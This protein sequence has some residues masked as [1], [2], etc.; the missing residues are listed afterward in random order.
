MVRRNWA[1][2]AQLADPNR[3][4]DASVWTA[5]AIDRLGQIAARMA[6][7]DRGD[8]LHAA[9]GL[10]DLRIGRNIIQVRLGLEDAE[11]YT[12][13]SIHSALSEVSALYL[14]RLRKGEALI[15][16]SSLLS[17]L[18]QAINVSLDKTSGLGDRALLALVGMRCNFIPNAKPFEVTPR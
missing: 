5:H 17:L 13:R 18:D 10:I 7:A 1:D 11:E 6:L 8:S 14:A 4:L 12:R 16:T 15:A 2:L 3:S 9:D